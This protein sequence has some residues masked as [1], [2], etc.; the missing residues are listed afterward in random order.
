MKKLIGIIGK[1]GTGK[2]TAFKIMF[3]NATGKVTVQRRAFAD[4]VKEY[5]KQ[6]FPS[7]VDLDRKD[8]VT[9]S[10]LQGLGHMFREK[11]DY[12]YWINQ[13]LSE[14]PEDA[15]VVLTD[16]RYENEALAVKSKGG[17]L[18]KLEGNTS[19]R[20]ENSQHP[21]ETSLD[22]FND[23][24]FLIENKGSLQDFE[25]EVIKWMNTQLL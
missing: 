20:G 15:I 1:A 14:L 24:D 10:V 22:N 7:L 5:A 25:K 2:D 6:Y 4:P 13:T 19:L 9:R 17:I 8:P 21:S 3:W 16:V 12:N 23:Y 11:V 18:L